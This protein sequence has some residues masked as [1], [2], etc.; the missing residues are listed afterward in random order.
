MY[1]LKAA[2]LWFVLVPLALSQSSN[3]AAADS[4]A[5]LPVTRVVLYK[6]GVGYFEHA[7]KV[8]DSQD[9]NVDFTTAQLN[10]VLKSLT[11]LDL[12]KGHITGVS[13]NSNAPLDRR[14][15]SLHLGVGE[16]PTTAQFLDALRGARLEV[17]SGGESAVGRLLSID[18]REIPIK[19]DQKISI[20]QISIISDSGEVRVFELNSSTSVRLAEKDVNEE[21]GKYLGLVASARDQDVRRMTIST[22]GNGERDLLV[23]YISEVPGM[24]EH[25][26]NRDAEGWQAAAARLGHRR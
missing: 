14:L 13:Y 8:R 11:V 25:L 17:K 26:P 15:G 16:N 2:T 20:D 24:E 1:S 6:N 10:D 23:S 12:G 4:N 7:G 9:V 3:S 21:V 19:G 5:R 18:E 22:A